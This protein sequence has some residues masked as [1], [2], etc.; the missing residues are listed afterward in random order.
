ML[1]CW[2][3]NIRRQWLDNG[4]LESDLT[5]K[6]RAIKEYNLQINNVVVS[7][8][9]KWSQDNSVLELTIYYQDR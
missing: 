6:R 7:V 1:K 4:H 9:E 8:I 3:T 5:M 2:Y